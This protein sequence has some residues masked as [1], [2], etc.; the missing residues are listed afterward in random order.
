[1]TVS[2][3]DRI[4]VGIWL[5]IMRCHTDHFASDSF[6]DPL[7]VDLQRSRDAVELPGLVEFDLVWFISFF[8]PL[9]VI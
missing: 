5:H 6:V 3:T 9:N 4:Y 7:M 2:T 1:M 8:L